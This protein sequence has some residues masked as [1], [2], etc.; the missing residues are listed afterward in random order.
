MR[1]GSIEK[2]PAKGKA[3]KKT[4]VSQFALTLFFP[5]KSRRLGGLRVLFEDT[6]NDTDRDV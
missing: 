4:V 5:L 6:E 3:A 2:R 1:A